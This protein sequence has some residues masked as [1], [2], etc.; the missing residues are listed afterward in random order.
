VT[1][2]LYLS[3]HFPPVGGAGVQRTLKFSRY[4]PELGFVPVVVTGPAVHRDR[5][6]PEDKSLL[7]EVPAEVEVARV[8]TPEPEPEAGWKARRER[9]LRSA[10]AWSR[11]WVSESTR[12]GLAVSDGAAVIL[13]SMSPFQSAR[14]ASE[15][16]RRLGIPWVA[17]LRDPWA[18]DEMTV[19]P[20]RA[21]RALALREMG[22]VLSTAAAVIMNTR[23]AAQRLSERLPDVAARVDVAV[24]P[25]G[26]DAEDFAGQAPAPHDASFRIVHAGYLHTALG[27]GQARSRWIRSALGG[28]IPGVSLLTRSHVYLLEALDRI[29]LTDPGLHRRIELH[30]AGVLSQEDLDVAQRAATVR[31]HGYLS[32]DDA[33]AL[34]R[35]ADLLFLPMHNLPSGRRATI[36]PGKTY[37]YLASSRPILAAVPDGDARDLLGRAEGVWL[38]RPDDATAM[39]EAIAMAASS[40]AAA[41]SRE[42]VLEPYE[43]R[44]LT[45]QL[46]D[47]LARVTRTKPH[48]A[49]AGASRRDGSPVLRQT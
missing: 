42:Q 23:D 6:T 9:W 35:S 18:L 3:Y 27:L 11:W 2:V 1:R 36:V 22:R 4:L 29:R 24:I 7:E 43:R 20:T 12:T 34:M 14:A 17:D 39:A 38:C 40:P 44:H 37:E 32:H 45:R 16:S 31:T 28:S 10:S 13:C 47:V 19:Y 48:E 49:V 25:N 15:L 5:W 26:F 33:V 21:H 30:L 46:A 41:H 8:E